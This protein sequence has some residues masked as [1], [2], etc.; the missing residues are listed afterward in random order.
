M[1]FALKKLYL[2]CLVKRNIFFRHSYNIININVKI[3][4][5]FQMI[6]II[7]LKSSD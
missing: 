2:F 6:H 3:Y 5:K 7:W 4:S 1:F